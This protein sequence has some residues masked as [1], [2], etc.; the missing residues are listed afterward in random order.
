MSTYLRKIN[1]IKQ[2]L[3]LQGGVL[4]GRY[5]INEIW[6]QPYKSL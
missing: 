5:N 3:G 2:F 4:L 6:V 1:Q